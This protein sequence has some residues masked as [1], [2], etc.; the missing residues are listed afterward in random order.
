[1][2]IASNA[3]YSSVFDYRSLHTPSAPTHLGGQQA[4]GHDLNF[5]RRG[6]QC[7]AAVVLISRLLRAH[8]MIQVR[9]KFRWAAEPLVMA[10]EVP[11]Q[12][13]VMTLVDQ[14]VFVR[15][16]VDPE[17]PLDVVPQ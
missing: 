9:E 16:L 8:E 4:F 10:T 17:C 12:V 3:G 1:M 11:M 2:I 6:T 15:L 14:D 7:A 5:L 13:I